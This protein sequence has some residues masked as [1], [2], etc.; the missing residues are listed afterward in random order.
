MSKSRVRPI[1]LPWTHAPDSDDEAAEC[2]GASCGDGPLPV[3]FLY[4]R[5]AWRGVLTAHSMQRLP[6]LLQAQWVLFVADV[7]WFCLPQEGVA[8]DR[9]YDQTTNPRPKPG[10]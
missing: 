3:P 1:G 10:V 5:A 8:L 7:C 2:I 4:N 6:P 9:I